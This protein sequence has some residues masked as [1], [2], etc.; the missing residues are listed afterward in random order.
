[1]ILKKKALN[2]FSQKKINRNIFKPLSNLI[3]MK[4]KSVLY[5]GCSMFSVYEGAGYKNHYTSGEKVNQLPPDPNKPEISLC[6][7]F[8]TNEEIWYESNYPFTMDRDELLM[9]SKVSR[10][11]KRIQKHGVKNP[12]RPLNSF[13]IYTK[14]EN[15]KSEYKDMQPRERLKKIKERWKNESKEVKDLFDCGANLAKERHARQHKEYHFT[16]K[17]QEVR[18]KPIINIKNDSPSNYSS[19]M[20]TTSFSSNEH[21]Q[22]NSPHYEF[23]F[24]NSIP[25][26]PLLPASFVQA[27]SVE[28]I[29]SSVYGLPGYTNNYDPSILS[30]LE[31]ELMMNQY[32]IPQ[33]QHLSN[34]AEC[35]APYIQP[36]SNFITDDLSNNEVF[37]VSQSISRDSFYPIF[38]LDD[39]PLSG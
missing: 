7:N 13:F 21:F 33:D 20:P 5:K 34:S 6:K 1:M 2:H 35:L 30:N 29:E 11:A 24:E 23:H 19:V 26:T 22:N 9:N 39:D 17:N 36:E 8:K 12:P 4:K 18:Q 31:L 32:S 27:D 38:E 10:R 14:N 16:K 15:N 3:T 37:L 25:P 28:S